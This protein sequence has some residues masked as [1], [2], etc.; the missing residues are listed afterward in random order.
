[1]MAG[2]TTQC[3]RLKQLTKNR[4]LRSPFVVNK[5]MVLTLQLDDGVVPLPIDQPH[6]ISFVA[7]P[8]YNLIVQNTEK[9]V[10]MVAKC[11][12]CSSSVRSFVCILGLTFKKHENAVT[13]AA[14]R[15]P[16]CQRN[17]PLFA[18]RDGKRPLIT[19]CHRFVQQ[20]SQDGKPV[21]FDAVLPPV[22][23]TKRVASRGLMNV[24]VLASKGRLAA[25]QSDYN[26]KI[27]LIV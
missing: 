15:D 3:L 21:H 4:T 5:V 27:V 19:S 7:L 18:V 12:S 24:L 11:R 20:L 13:K 10:P 6:A 9:N 22:G 8:N 14:G 26:G 1:M 2:V 16:H 17:R 23:T 25:R